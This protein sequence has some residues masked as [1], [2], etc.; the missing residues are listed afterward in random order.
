MHVLGRAVLVG[1]GKMSLEQCA[2]VGGARIV[3]GYLVAGHAKTLATTAHHQVPTD[4]GTSVAP[5]GGAQQL[6]TGV[7]YARR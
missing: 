7:A 5:R 3:R 6:R 2:D 1:E 4:D